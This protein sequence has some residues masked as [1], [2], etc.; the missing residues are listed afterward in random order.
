MPYRG[1]LP[2]TLVDRV[3]KGVNALRASP[4]WGRLAGRY[5]TEVTYVGRRSGRT[6]STP[7]GYRRRGDV[8]TI[9]VMIPESKKWWRNFVDEGQP[10]SLRLDGV[11]RTGHAVAR[12]DARGRV[13]LTVH[14]DA[15]Q[16]A[17]PGVDRPA[18]PVDTEH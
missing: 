13:A 7:V 18:K 12:R 4:R 11:D 8:V 14:L 6:I 10:M 17:D 2:R 15:V 9:P 1:P 16:P 3:N 5:L